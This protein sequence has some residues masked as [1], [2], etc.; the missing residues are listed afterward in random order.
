LTGLHQSLSP[1]ELVELTGVGYSIILPLEFFHNMAEAGAA[2]G[3]AVSTKDKQLK[4]VAV[5]T[6]FTAFIGISEPALYSV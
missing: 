2:L 1:I 3:T 4:A 5:Q 6:G